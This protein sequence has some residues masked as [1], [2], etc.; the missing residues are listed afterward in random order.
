VGHALMDVRR[1]A[2][3]IMTLD[4]ATTWRR[5][6]SGV[7]VFTNGVFD[8]IHPGHVEVLERARAEGDRLIVAVNDDDSARRLDK[9]VDRPIMTVAARMQ[10]VAGMESTDCVLSFSEDTPERVVEALSPNVL[11]KGSDYEG[12]PLPGEHHVLSRG[13]RVVLIPFVHG[14]ST[15]TIVERIRAATG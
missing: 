11:V 6:Q 13:G 5:Q 7:V 15:S 9:G 1:A 4:A 2:E 3:K 8:I 10:V 14:H 12:L